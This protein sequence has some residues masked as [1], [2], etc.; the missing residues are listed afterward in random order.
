MA[1]VTIK[2]A[3]IIGLS[4][5]WE[6][7]QRG[8]KVQVI[9]P[10]GVGAGSSGGIVGALAPHVPEN[11][12]EKK[13]FQFESL[14]M[15][16]TFWEYVDRTSGLNSGYARTGRIQPLLDEAGLSLAQERGENAKSLWQGMAEWCVVDQK[17]EWVPPSPT[18]KWIFDSLSARIQPQNAVASIAQ[19]IQKSG[20]EIHH[21]AAGFRKGCMGSWGM[22]FKTH[23]GPHGQKFRKWR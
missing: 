18:G 22:G 14:Q 6:C 17:P 16:Q 7:I 4:I 3:G 2:G 13:A 5:A 8:A 15:A 21:S 10:H 20:G 1:E 23:I 12:N 11:W 9:D 19:A